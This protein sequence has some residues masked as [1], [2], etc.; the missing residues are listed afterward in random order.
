MKKIKVL[1]F[2]LFVFLASIE[3]VY[4]ACEAQETNKLNSLAANVKANY[5]IV[6][7][8]I[9]DFSSQFNPPD[10]LTQEELENHIFYED[11]ANIHIMNLTE[12][13]YVKVYD[14]VS[15][16]TVT[17]SYSD[18]NNG[19]I[20]IKQKNFD[21]VNNYTIT[22]YSSDK[23][24]CKDTR[25]Y[26]L[27]VTIPRFNTLSEYLICENAREF[28]M[29]HEYVTVDLD[30]RT[31]FEKVNDYIENKNNDQDDDGQGDD[32]KGFFEEYKN[33]IIIVVV[34][35]VIIGGTTTV[36]IVKRQ[37]RIV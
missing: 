12:E 19:A 14:S 7:E 6:E 31:F 17:Y 13:L 34:A 5:E 28:Y 36:I 23:T 18:S 11:V 27:Y 25:L 20:T 37:R 22:V 30:E 3:V 4:A 32:N 35:I 33:V 8:E 1:V 16:E 24:N 26:T 9:K 29:C 21:K 15:N 10:T 2:A